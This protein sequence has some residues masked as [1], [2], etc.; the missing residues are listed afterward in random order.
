[1]NMRGLCRAIAVSSLGLALIANGSAPPSPSEPEL[2]LEAI[3]A[4]DE[5]LLS[6]Q[7]GGFTFAGMTIALGAEF[8]T[9]LNGELVMRTTVAWRPEGQER[10]EWVSGT[11][12]PASSEQLKAGILSSGGITMTVGNQSVYLA[13]Q[14]AT[15]LIHR[16]DGGLQNV[17]LNTASNT[18]IRQEADIAL[19]IAGYEGFGAGIAEASRIT[20]IHSAIEQGNI[21]SLGD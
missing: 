13:N 18:S 7:R 11:L 5:S 16:T 21:G 14:G 6:E 15:A 19:D 10:D 17:I 4:L 3:E 20:G 2:D 8:R 12:T 1:M 9:F